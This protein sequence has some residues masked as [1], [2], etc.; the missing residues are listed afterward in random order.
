M[1]HRFFSRAIQENLRRDENDISDLLA[2][3]LQRGRERGVPGY[4]S[5][6]RACGLTPF[7]S[8]D[9]FKTIMPGNIVERMRYLYK[10]HEDVD[11]FAGGVMERELPGGA[12]GPTFACII[13]EQFR[14]LRFGDRFWYERADPTVGFTAPQLTELRKASLA[15]LFCD[16]SDNIGMMPKRLLSIQSQ[17]VPCNSLPTVDLRYWKE[18]RNHY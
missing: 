1:C 14:N 16:N 6:R 12:L 9:D 5:F 7:T 2:I 18:L 15:R 17:P 11:L 10:S 8:F 4:N 3:N 13:A